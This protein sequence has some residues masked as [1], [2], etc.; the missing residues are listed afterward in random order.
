MWRLVHSADDWYAVLE[1]T[2]IDQVGVIAS[3]I[4]RGSTIVLG[5][6]IGK[7][8]RD[9]QVDPN[10]II[11]VDSHWQPSPDSKAGHP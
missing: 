6:N 11:I 4:E 7:M 3:H 8:A 1:E 10:D 9:I 5:E 2:L